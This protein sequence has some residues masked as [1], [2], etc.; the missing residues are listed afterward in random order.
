MGHPQ[1]KRKEL[2][3]FLQAKDFK[4]E[5]LVIQTDQELYKTY[6]KLWKQ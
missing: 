4:L 1:F 2:I 3:S 5:D 6:L